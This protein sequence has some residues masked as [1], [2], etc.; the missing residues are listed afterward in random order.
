MK[1]MWNDYVGIPYKLHGRDTDGLDCW[2]LV[3][4]IYKDQK[5]IDLP[6]LSEE[7]FASDDVSH[8]QEVIARHKEGW[9]LVN[10]YTVG[11]VALFRIN[12]SESHVGVIIDQN[13]FIHAREGNSV[14]IEKLDSVQWRRRLVGVYKY[15][16]KVEAY[17]H[18]VVNPLKTLRLDLITHPGQS[19]QDIVDA[20]QTKQKLDPKIFVNHILFLDGY[21][22][23]KTQWATT[24]LKE[25]QHVDYRVVPTGGGAGRLLGMIAIMAVAW[26]A[27][28]MLTG[29]ALGVSGAAFG[30]AGY[31]A[32]GAAV[33]AGAVTAGSAALAMSLATM[34]VNLV[35]SLLV[36]AL[37]PI[38]PAEQ[39]N[40]GAFKN[41]NLI[42]GGSNREN[43]YGSIP[44]VL[45]RLRYTP[46]VGAK[47][48]VEN[49]GDTSY[50]R[51]LAIWGYG[52]LQ[53]T[54]IK[55]GN[56]AL[57]S[58][59]EVEYQTLYGTSE[60]SSANLNKF[61]AI[62]GQDV[63][64][65]SPNLEL[66]CKR[67]YLNANV[68]VTGGNTFE[69]TVNDQGK[70]KVHDLQITD[71]IQTLSVN[72][73]NSEV[74]VLISNLVVTQIISETKFKC[75]SSTSGFTNGTY[76]QYDDT[77]KSYFTGGNPWSEFTIG[78]EVDRVGVT[79][80]FPQGL[81]GIS[82][83]GNEGEREVSVS[84]QLRPVG[85]TTW[86]EAYE[87]VYPN[88]FT[89]SSA[90][91]NINDDADL[92]PVYQW[93]YVNVTSEGNLVLRTGSITN[94][95][96]ANPSGT[97]LTRLQ[98]SSGVGFDSTFEYLPAVLSQEQTIY[99]VCV[100]GN[101]ITDVVDTRS[102][103]ITSGCASNIAAGTGLTAAKFFSVETG[104]ISRIAEGDPDFDLAKSTFYLKDVI[105]YGYSKN[106]SFNVSRANYEV[107]VKRTSSN[108]H[109]TDTTSDTC[110]LSSITGYT[111]TKPI[112]LPNDSYGNPIKLARSAFKIRS[113]GQINGLVEGV[114]ATVQTLGEDFQGGVWVANQP[115]RNPAALF[116]Y[117]LKHAGNARASSV[118][119]DDTTINSWYTYCKDNGFN[120][121]KI[122]LDAVSLLDVLKD[123]AAAGRASP[124]MVDGKWSVVID[125]PKTTIAQHFTPHNSWGFEG[126]RS[127][128]QLPNAF[129][130]NFN[131]AEK[132]WQA[133]EMIV[134]NDGFTS[135]NS[136]LF[137][138]IE[139]PGVTEPK[140]VYKHAR[141]H[142]AQLKLRPEIYTLNTDIEHV[143]CTRGDRVKVVHDV[144]MWGLGSA[145][146]K[147]VRFNLLK[148]SEEFNNAAWTAANVA[149]ANNTIV[150]PNGTLT[151]DKL[152][153]TAVS[154]QHRVDQTVSVT[155]GTTYTLTAYA[156]AAEYSTL[157]LRT[158]NDTASVYF[159]LLTGQIISASGGSGSIT[160]V[161]NGWYR[162]AAT[163][164]A[165]STGASVNARIAA[166]TT[167]L[168]VSYTG[169]G[170]SGIYIWGAQLETGS[171]ATDY[172]KSNAAS[173]TAIY[174]DE[175]MPV[176]TT[177]V[178][179]V[180][181]RNN[182]NSSFVKTIQPVLQNE[183]YNRLELA[184][185]SSSIFTS[186]DASSDNL[187]PDDLLLFG[188]YN[189]ES[190]DLIVQSIEPSDN[191][192]ARLTLVDYSPAI[193]NSDSE[194][195]P[196][197]NSQ[198]TKP[199]GSLESVITYIPTIEST[200][201][202][203]DDKVMEKVGPSSFI[204]KM[205]V[206]VTPLNTTNASLQ[207]IR[208]L[209]GEIKL[210]TGKV[211]QNSKNVPLEEKG[212]LF[213]SV[214]EGASYDI[215]IRYI[216]DDGKVGA[217]ST[218]ATHTVLGKTVAPADATG[219]TITPDNLTGKL[220]LKWNAN[221]EID[222]K[223]YEV[224]TEDA[225]WGI[226]NAA[227]VFSGSANTCTADPAAL[228]V[229]KT[230]YLR[231]LDFGKLY[232][233]ASISDSYTVAAPIT[234]VGTITSEYADSSTT[235][236][237]V[238][239]KWTAAPAGIFAIDKYEVT[240][241]KP[242]A[243]VVQEISGLTWTTLA[244]WVGN[245]SVTIKSIDILGN[246]SVAA[247]T[248]LVVGK[249]RPTAPA[250][251]VFTVADAQVYVDWSDVTKTSLP[252]A[253]YEI[254]KNNT[255]WG[256]NDANFVW[257]GSVSNAA[258]KGLIAGANN[259]YINTFD[260]D[261][262][263]ASSG[264]LI[265]YTVQRPAIA[266]GLAATFSDTSTTNALVKFDWVAPAVTTFGVKKYT[267]VLTKPSG[268]SVTASLDSTTWTVNADWVGTATLTITTVDM[269]DITSASNATLSVVKSAPNNVGTVTFTP[270]VNSM[271]VKWT[272]V[273]KTTLPIDGY[274]IRATN[275]GWGTSSGLIWRG[276]TNTT[277]IGSLVT[278]SN[279]FFIRAFDTE[280]VY[281]TTSTS[282]D[283]VVNAPLQSSSLVTT[284]AN[285]STSGTTVTFNWTGNKGTFDIASYNITLTKPGSIV[286]A[287][288]VSANTFTTAADWLGD[289]TLSI[290]AVDTSNN[291]GAAFTSTIGKTRPVA[292]TTVTT[293]TSPTGLTIAWNEGV[294][295][296]L[297]IA[298]YELRATGT[299]PGG[300]D[301]I[302]K[303][304]ASSVTVSNLVLGANTWD[305]WAFDTDLR[306]SSVAR[307]V[308][309][310]AVRPT[311]V[312]TLS[313]VFNTSLTNSLAEFKW[314]KP[315]TSVFDIA[316]YEVS[317]TTTNPVRTI[318]S[319]RLT[320]DWAVPADW[321]GDA[322]L[323]VTAYDNLGFNSVA[324]TFVLS[325]VVPNQPGA[326][327]APTVKGTTL[328]LD[329]PD[330]IKT[331]LPIVGYELR[332][333]DDDWGGTGFIW[334][335][336]ASNTSVDMVGVL[337]D[338]TSS[339]YLKAYDSDNRY[340]SSARLYE[341]TVAAPVNTDT[342]TYQ[343]VDTSLT[344]AT[345]TLRWLD[346]SPVFGLK[347]YEIT[348]KLSVLTTTTANSNLLTLTSTKGILVNDVLSGNANIPEGRRVTQIINSTQLYVDNASGIL[349][350]T[351][352]ATSYNNINYSNS[353]SV[354]QDADWLGDKIYTIRTV[355]LIGN[356]STGTSVSATKE[357]PNAASNLK[358]QVIDNTV[359]LYWD[360]PQI[361]SL[362]ISHVLI[363]KGATWNTA[364]PIGTKSGTFTTITELQGG[365]YNYWVAVVDTDNNESLPISI[366][367]TVSQP[368]DYIFNAEYVS[369]FTGTKSNAIIEA[370]TGYLVLPVNTVESF[371]SHF[372]TRSWNT[373][374]D[375]ITAGF[376]IYIQ[377]G[378]TSGY[379]EEVFD[380]GTSLGSSQITVSISG[381]NIAGSPDISVIISSSLDGVTYTSFPAG[382]SAFATNFR[383]I[384]VRITATQVTSGNIYSI[385]GLV[386]RLDAKQRT[387]SGS[388]VLEIG[389][390]H[391]QGSVISDYY[392][393]TAGMSMPPSGYTLYGDPS[394]NIIV[395][396]IGP[397]ASNEN[398]WACID[399]DTS[400]LQDGGFYSSSTT[401]D[402]T[403]GYMFAVF[404]KTT[405]N[406]GTS[407]F[408]PSNNS[409]I[410][411]LVGTVNSNPYFWYGDLPALNTWYLL[412]GY[413]YPSS[414]GTT[415][416]GISG[417]Y[418]MSGTKVVSTTSFK[419]T[420]GA[421]QSY[422]RCFHYANPAGTGDQVQFMAR[423]VV[424]QCDAADAAS[425][426][427]YLLKCTNDYGATVV[428]NINYVDVTSITT[429]PNSVNPTTTVVDFY[430]KPYPTRFNIFN[431]NSA[432]V[433]VGG[434]IS[435]TIR[436]Y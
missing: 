290:V 135:S 221:T 342:V 77:E 40:A 143:I 166:G 2:G 412:V 293:T 338:T 52:P 379:Y 119:I 215:R 201:I 380:Y 12:G 368:P 430:D 343:F 203:S 229:A 75:Q 167:G 226:D 48:F 272:P 148:Y 339:W 268:G 93:Y 206:P 378:T 169:D 114:T 38:R 51:M 68:I 383:Y 371:S 346:T 42:Q 304:T 7:Y 335:G 128:P 381:V 291:T 190:I 258:L 295:G 33:T 78:Q 32:M 237:T 275:T 186:Y 208:Y 267:V 3:R 69:V 310:T 403:K 99:K 172:I 294:K 285:T 298:G 104:I 161:G 85:Q 252:V 389:A 64:Q 262:V 162:C 408:G 333:S 212:I 134:Y 120:F 178:Y 417:I 264:T 407:Y 329:W 256:T 129:R 102:G 326:F 340:S 308:S 376:P 260:T 142:L 263:Y 23:S 115:I 83:S 433:N 196:A 273:T 316:R 146:I 428:P 397:S 288:N 419:F 61:D 188:E 309:Y 15:T 147:D 318:N 121:D 95:K 406:N 19:L 92:E 18:A 286:T 105:K 292:P 219:L 50:L 89:L 158:A 303:G 349:A 37:F 354:T 353:T 191:M 6:S 319:T 423:P 307:A 311:I 153:A 357:L 214:V 22:V 396:A 398:I 374:T 84:I 259:W 35:G 180:R 8:N 185:Y 63:T 125:V 248:A 222:L 239:L 330:T 386:V 225:N 97:L 202:L 24:I 163:G 152:I 210:S 181:I 145:R 422:L 356:K 369:T 60:D 300:N 370:N 327:L 435:W 315:S 366:A 154:G 36:N 348:G 385:S 139:L 246:K 174:L 116:R 108:T 96:N 345:I 31:A 429:T 16:S 171:V 235:N 207:K 234:Y 415:D 117:V 414:Y 91:Y 110:I 122:I 136:T 13:R 47:T 299:T 402:S 209:Q 81:Y 373:P 247:S 425:K 359:L 100:Y 133:D 66:E 58:Y 244:N 59:D 106:I 176:T 1:K 170:Y 157:W 65:Q 198:I 227:L 328:S 277:S 195:I 74:K 211:W 200:K 57:S 297:P 387:D 41:T 377:P 394:E 220:I 86:N 9:A 261:N 164:V 90:Y 265:T 382:T 418:N 205:L 279:V 401:V 331:S 79:L 325:K 274:E 130:V 179:A 434:T 160:P 213:S 14:T 283:L 426:I 232:S 182:N 238:T 355:D 184:N 344:S 43:Q 410:A 324:E 270:S 416:G 223:G 337:S 395:N 73:G 71:P 405:T 80:N 361:T 276:V 67:Q 218:V 399:A 240:I 131:N 151:G 411:N 109:L 126:T 392:T 159:D 137:E 123:I 236:S 413:V 124:T 56:V 404:I 25:G 72:L 144:P 384:K 45:G 34:G 427:S 70:N 302:W 306:Y 255:G 391:A 197:F 194:V 88:G 312:Q 296:S 351:S 350:G 183:Y 26:Y 28:P 352:V 332:S 365:L 388:A 118:L 193:Y 177:S 421:I 55:L 10:D 224:R 358:A 280:G 390:A 138:T 101:V 230:F 204:Y 432:G 150:A 82:S 241:T 305:L 409:L 322:T 253:G 141:F 175:E 103:I 360:L 281:S 334:K 251:V 49:D 269:L 20:L 140:N 11:D 424:I 393:W 431:Y 364:V 62:Y 341:Y 189:Q 199:P 266:T 363:K 112:V 320:T 76:V 257:R 367:A 233:I 347:H 27:A 53:V 271:I 46:P 242:T 156:K 362:P 436:G 375:Q 30:S 111:N 187:N 400:V 173:G 94:N 313:G 323:S 132:G 44:V 317:L 165:T 217:W 287:A 155:S 321:L 21:P 278:G 250:S 29:S 254:R 39:G 314:V 372:T 231:A 228:G 216:S 336:S 127:F 87:K 17:V 192:S 282:F 149:I 249:L 98:Q 107:R 54:D 243:T 284:Y 301:Y 289:A 113:T 168:T 245:A 5:D 4:L 420:S